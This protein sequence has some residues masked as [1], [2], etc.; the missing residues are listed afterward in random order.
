MRLITYD[1]VD[2]NAH[3]VDYHWAL[4]AKQFV[5]CNERVRAWY[6]REKIIASVYHARHARL[7]PMRIW[8]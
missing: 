4:L 2:Y 6:E 1:P 8:P 5:K 3:V 7:Y